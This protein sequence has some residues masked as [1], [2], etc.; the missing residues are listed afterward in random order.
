MPI[1][2]PTPTSGDNNS[3]IYSQIICEIKLRVD[4][5]I[6]KL[7]TNSDPDNGISSCFLA[8]ATLASK[9]PDD[10]SLVIHKGEVIEWKD[11]YNSW[12][13]SNK[14]ANYPFKDEMVKC[15]NNN[16]DYLISI[17]SDLPKDMW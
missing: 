11:K 7:K 17:G 12:I 4:K 16:L 3:L 15:N 2:G 1:F 8:L 14:K 10:S 5:T 13:E 9:S 6:S